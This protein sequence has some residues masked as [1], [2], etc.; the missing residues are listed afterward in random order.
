VLNFI[1][2]RAWLQ[3]E[4]ILCKI[5][6]IEMKFGSLVLCSIKTLYLQIKIIM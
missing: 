1:F 2:N 5:N 3:V 6:K 4:K